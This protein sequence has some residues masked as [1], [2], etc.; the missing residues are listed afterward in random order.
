M[1]KAGDVVSKESVTVVLEKE[2]KG[3]RAALL[4]NESVVS[5]YY[6]SDAN[7][8]RVG[9]LFIGR[10]L[11]NR[12]SQVGWFVDLGDGQSGFLPNHKQRPD[13]TVKPDERIIV[14]VD[15]EERDGK[16]PELTEQVQ[17]KGKNLIFLPFSPYVAVSRRLPENLR[18]HLKKK[19]SEWCAPGEGAIIRTQA[20]EQ[21]LAAILEEFKSLKGI[22]STLICTA[23]NVSSEKRVL[24][25]FSFATALLNEN[26]FPQ[27]STV[28]ANFLINQD[29]L[30]PNTKFIYKEHQDLFSYLNLESAYKAALRPYVPLESGASLMIEYTEA[31]TAIDVNSGS[32][33][34]H[35][36]WEET[37]FRINQSAAKEI[38]KQL[39]LRQIG[40]MVVI[41]FLRME[42]D[43]NRYQL[44]HELDC[45]TK[46]DPNAVQVFGFTRLGLVELVR[47][48]QRCGLRDRFIQEEN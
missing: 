29:A 28:I 16:V 43:E 36:N 26:H 37:A 18:E 20:G 39:R 2:N 38:A 12:F 1:W 6:Q 19:V 41:D 24:R 7:D 4:E 40:G 10:I 5:F 8:V 17:I 42:K 45:L 11:K 23:K 46:N 15:K 47:R 3:V 33:A 48:R 31:L 44:L 34:I 30:P 25:Q 13:H 32:T 14:Q 22:A 21:D 35:N 27:T 9:D